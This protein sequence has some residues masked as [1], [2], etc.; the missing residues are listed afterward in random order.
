MS[1][2]EIETE[3]ETEKPAPNEIDS[4]ICVY[5]HTKVICM[6]LLQS[7]EWNALATYYTVCTVAVCDC[8]NLCY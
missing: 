3:T 7:T 6:L 8:M 5:D 4:A 2:K 1:R